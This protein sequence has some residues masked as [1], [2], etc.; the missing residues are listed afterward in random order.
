MV[1]FRRLSASIK[2]DD[3]ICCHTSTDRTA[4]VD[5]L[6]NLIF[7]IRW[8]FRFCVRL[9]PLIRVPPML[10]LWKLIAVMYTIMCF[11]NVGK[12]A[13]K[14]NALPDVHREASLCIIHLE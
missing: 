14:R 6:R 7:Y 4:V 3:L 11:A 13:T 2:T 10:Y 12:F 1:Q 9:S 8:K 5:P